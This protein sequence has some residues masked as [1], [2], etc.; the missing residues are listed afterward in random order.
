MA[1]FQSTTRVMLTKR[2]LSKRKS[3]IPPMKTTRMRESGMN[4]QRNLSSLRKYVKRRMV[5]PGKRIKS[6]Q[7]KTKTGKILRSLLF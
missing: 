3:L 6:K 1:N 7:L 4:I 5:K 2:T